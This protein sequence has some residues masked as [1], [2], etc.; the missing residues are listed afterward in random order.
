MKTKNLKF[1]AKFVVV[2]E[3]EMFF[4]DTKEEAARALREFGC[5]RLACENQVYKVMF[6]LL[7]PAEL[8]YMY[9]FFD[10]SKD[11]DDNNSK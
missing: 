2:H 5:G 11:S 4:M 7:G 3:G 9:G 1:D 8:D 10:G 6:S